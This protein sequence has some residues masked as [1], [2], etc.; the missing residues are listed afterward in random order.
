MGHDCVM[1][2]HKDALFLFQCLFDWF[3]TFFSI[4]ASFRQNNVH[5]PAQTHKKKKQLKNTQNYTRTRNLSECMF[6]K[7]LAESPWSSLGS[8]RT[9]EHAGHMQWQL[10]VREKKKCI[11]LFATHFSRHCLP[12]VWFLISCRS[13]LSHGCLPSGFLIRDSKNNEKSR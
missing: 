10:C 3:A 7:L 1:F 12:F 2:D 11:Q 5:S 4:F 13:S 8:E 9:S 6:I